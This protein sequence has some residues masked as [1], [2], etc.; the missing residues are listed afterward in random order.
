MIAPDFALRPVAEDDLDALMDVYRQCE[1]FLALGPQAWASQD[2]VLADLAHSREMGGAFHGIYVQGRMV[3]VMDYVPAGFE[4]NPEHAFLSLLMIAAPWRG[5]GLGAAVVA[6]GEQ[7]I[8]RNPS[9]RAI[10]SGVQ[11]NNAAGI[12]FWQRMDYEICGG[13]KQ[14]EDTT[15]CYDLIKRLYT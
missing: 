7:D 8:R 10:L 9:V 5:S 15:I 6:A 13:P 1:D 2:M 3:G 12:A 4:G 11:V 14:M